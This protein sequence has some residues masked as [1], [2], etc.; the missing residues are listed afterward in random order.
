MTEIACLCYC[1]PRVASTMT[2]TSTDAKMHLQGHPQYL[3][4]TTTH[5]L[6]SIAG[7]LSFTLLW[8]LSPIF[9]G[10]RTVVGG[11][12]GACHEEKAL[13]IPHCT[14]AK[15]FAKPSDGD[16]SAFLLSDLGNEGSFTSP[17]PAR[18]SAI[19]VPSLL[20]IMSDGRCQGL[21]CLG[22]VE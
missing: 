12:G 19:F 10:S 18:C 1:I 22:S 14:L 20:N 9:G 4:K 15:G 3:R 13:G 21:S 11:V 5:G 16:P 7:N 17:R 8:A 6:P 2:T